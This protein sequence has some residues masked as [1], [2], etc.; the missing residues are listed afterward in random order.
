MSS[1]DVADYFKNELRIL[2]FICQAFEGDTKDQVKALDTLLSV[3][4]PSYSSGLAS[5]Y[6][7]T[8]ESAASSAHVA[9]PRELFFASSESDDSSITTHKSSKKFI[10]PE[11][12]RPLIMQCIQK[13]S[14]NPTSRKSLGVS[15]QTPTKPSSTASNKPI[16]KGP[17][18]KRAPV[19]NGTSASGA[20]NTINPAPSPNLSPSQQSQSTAV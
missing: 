12:W 18:V 3:S 16:A 5:D 7:N 1:N 4:S 15:S 20:A 10:V 17:V 13:P 9:A 6:P 8:P 11:K 2:D 19:G 14:S